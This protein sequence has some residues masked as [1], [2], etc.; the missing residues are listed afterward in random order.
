MF[1]IGMPHLLLLAAIALIAI[2]PKQLPEVARVI[3]RFLNDL[4]KVRDEF[5]RTIVESRDNVN[6]NLYNDQPIYQPEPYTPEPYTPLIPPPPAVDE[7]DQMAFDLHHPSHHILPED[8]IALASAEASALEAKAGT[9][10]EL[11]T[12]ASS[13]APTAVDAEKKDS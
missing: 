10:P 13:A 9:Q 8:A 11:P 3:G 6:Q 4:K 1:G 2:G 12:K 7:L 5:T